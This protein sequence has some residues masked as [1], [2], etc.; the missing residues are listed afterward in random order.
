VNRV[1]AGFR[2]GDARRLWGCR[3]I[4]WTPR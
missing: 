1:S 2:H 3:V 4:L